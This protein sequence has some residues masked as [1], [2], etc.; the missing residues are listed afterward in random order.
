MKKEAIS[1]LEIL[2]DKETGEKIVQGF[3]KI[4]PEKCWQALKNAVHD[5]ANRKPEES[6]TVQR[7]SH[8]FPQEQP[9]NTSS[10]EV[11]SNLP[12]NSL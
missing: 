8:F 3:K 6:Q 11:P 7:K 2:T 10:C 12:S 9:K 4:F 1:Y 5:C